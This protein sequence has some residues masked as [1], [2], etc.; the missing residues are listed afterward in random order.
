MSLNDFC[1]VG[2]F[3]LLIPAASLRLQNT[4]KTLFHVNNWYFY[5]RSIHLVY[6]AADFYCGCPFFGFQI[7]VTDLR[8]CM[9]GQGSSFCMWCWVF[10]WCVIGGWISYAIWKTMLLRRSH[11]A[12]LW[13]LV[14]FLELELLAAC[15]LLDRVLVLPPGPCADSLLIA[16]ICTPTQGSLSMSLVQIPVDYQPQLL[17]QRV[18]LF[19][20]SFVSQHQTGTT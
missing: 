1:S 17:K 18:G 10:W 12:F 8:C 16:S 11:V 13:H 19:L 9:I 5:S 2:F 6:V 14:R 7:Y 4:T 3:L 15:P 20:L